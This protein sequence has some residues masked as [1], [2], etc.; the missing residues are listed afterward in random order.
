MKKISTP[1]GAW[2]VDKELQPRAGQK[3]GAVPVHHADDGEG[4]EEIQPEEPFLVNG[5]S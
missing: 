3:Q 2:G 1:R 4:P 5:Y